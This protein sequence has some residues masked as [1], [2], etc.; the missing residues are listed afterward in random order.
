MLILRVLLVPF[1]GSVI[2]PWRCACSHM[3]S[4]VSSVQAL[5]VALDIGRTNSTGQEYQNTDFHQHSLGNSGKPHPMQWY[6]PQCVETSHKSSNSTIFCVDCSILK[7]VSVCVFVFACIL[8]GSFHMRTQTVGILYIN[9]CMYFVYIIYCMC[10]SIYQRHTTCAECLWY[11]GSKHFRRTT[12]TRWRQ[13]RR[14]SENR[15]S[16]KVT[17]SNATQPIC[18]GAALEQLP[19]CVHKHPE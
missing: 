12:T 6:V 8:C 17:H 7:V 4:H 10:T 13:L 19:Q 14:E 9:E 5:V 1:P 15:Y 11:R 3:H 18:L 2:L 16:A